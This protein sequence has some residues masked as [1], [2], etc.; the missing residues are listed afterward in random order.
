MYW[1]YRNYGKETIRWRFD[2]AKGDFHRTAQPL[3]RIFCIR[4]LNVGGNWPR[5]TCNEKM[6][7][8]VF[9]YSEQTFNPSNRS[10]T[11]FFERL[12]LHFSKRSSKSI[13]YSV[14]NNEVDFLACSVVIVFMEESTVSLTGGFSFSTG[15]K[16]WSMNEENQWRNY[17]YYCSYSNRNLVSTRGNSLN[18]GMNLFHYFQRSIQVWVLEFAI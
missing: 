1:V 3:S 15:K 2:E 5:K 6:H 11:T 17:L 12:L 9:L 14:L 8:S 4:I 13:K 10:S 18:E 7:W 16:I